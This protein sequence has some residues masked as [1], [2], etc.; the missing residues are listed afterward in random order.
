M[1][2]KFEIS[3]RKNGHYQFNLKAGNSQVIL[4]SEGYSSIE[5][6]REGIESVR[7][8]AASD[9]N[10]ERKTAKDGSAYFTL[11]AS[12]GEVIGTS[13]TYASTS[14]RDKGIGSVGKNAPS[15]SLVD[16]TA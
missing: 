2:A 14:G 11:K 16:K 12:N 15:A 9:A 6:C 8:H 13:E 4:T 5:K 7:M 3:K 1:P 10:F